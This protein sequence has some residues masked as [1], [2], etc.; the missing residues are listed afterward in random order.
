[1]NEPIDAATGAPGTGAPGGDFDPGMTPDQQFAEMQRAPEMNFESIPADGDPLAPVEAPAEAPAKTP[2]ETPVQPDPAPATVSIA[3]REYTHEQLAEIFERGTVDPAVKVA[4]DQ[5]NGL[6]AK[7]QTAEGIREVIASLETALREDFGQ[8]PVSVELPGED[9]LVGAE[10]QFRQ[11][12]VNQQSKI[13]AL[14][15]QLDRQAQ[16]IQQFGSTIKELEPI[17]QEVISSRQ[18]SAE[19]SAVKAKLGLDVTPQEISHAKQ[20]TGVNDPVGA[21]ATLNVLKGQQAPPPPRTP[22]NGQ[23]VPDTSK[24]TEDEHFALLQRGVVTGG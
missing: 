9:E 17:H 20:Q 11:A 8:A 21:I 18:A 5:F 6:I 12:I 22:T 4:A 10:V 1:M 15:A 13:A 14:E 7:T 3:G 2:A 19:V 16:I 24:L 23:R